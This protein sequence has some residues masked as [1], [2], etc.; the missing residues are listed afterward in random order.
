MAEDELRAVLL[1]EALQPF[2]RDVSAQLGAA[3]A[4]GIAV[5]LDSAV[6][7]VRRA[8]GVDRALAAAAKVERIAT[9]CIILA[10]DPF[11]SLMPSHR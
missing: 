3:G 2:A 4:A 9:A 1:A 11:G 5:N 6:H 8:A 10:S 7:H